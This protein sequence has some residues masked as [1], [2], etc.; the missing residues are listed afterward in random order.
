MTWVR[1]I[2]FAVQF[3][4]ILPIPVGG[5]TDADLAAMPAFFPAVGLG[6]GLVLWGLDRLLVF[7]DPLLRA[8]VLVTAYTGVTGGLH[9]DGLMDTFDAWGSRRPA[10]EALRVMKDSRLGASGALAGILALLLK[11]AAWASLAAPHPLLA[12]LVPGISRTAMLLAMAVEPPARPPQDSLG[13]RTARHVKPWWAYCWAVG[14]LTAAAGLKPGWIAP[15]GGVA[16]L[17]TAWGFAHGLS[18]RFGGMTG[19]TYG[20]VNEIAEVIGWVLLAAWR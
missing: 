6:L 19:D 15:V 13:A 11:V 12:A 16:V 17:A 4:T 18:R 9:L 14:L 10:A 3:L 7:W 5:V 8:A 20:A 2:S 1:R